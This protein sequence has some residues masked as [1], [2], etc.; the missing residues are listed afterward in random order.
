MEN[1]PAGFE[2]WK[3]Y[4]VA[5]HTFGSTV[6]AIIEDLN[7]H[8][9]DHITEADIRGILKDIGQFPKSEY[10]WQHWIMR[11]TNEHIPA[12]IC[13]WNSWSSRFISNCKAKNETNSTIVTK[14]RKRG[15][16][17]P[18]EH[19]VQVVLDEQLIIENGLARVCGTH[20]GAILEEIIIMAHNWG[21]TVPETAC[22]IF[23]NAPSR[24]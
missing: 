19:C 16:E 21:Y 12:G 15:Y 8:G 7:T 22:R 9:Q 14:M 2:A 18:G 23:G 17:I 13:P 20:D 5:A 10:L 1:L 4:I 6:A 3:R 24:N 11:A